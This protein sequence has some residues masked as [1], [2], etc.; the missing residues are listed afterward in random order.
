MR[1][2]ISNDD[3]I[4]SPGLAALERAASAAGLATSGMPSSPA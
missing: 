4:H 1:A 2:L 3:G